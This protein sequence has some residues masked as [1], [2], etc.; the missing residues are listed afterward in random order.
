MTY[1]KVEGHIDLVR[2]ETT[3]AVLNTNLTEYQKYMSLKKAKESETN[4]IKKL[5]S[6]VND[7]K[8]DLGEIKNLLRSLVDGS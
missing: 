4:R 6:D 5:E 2:D 3:G 1:S 7:M 8:S